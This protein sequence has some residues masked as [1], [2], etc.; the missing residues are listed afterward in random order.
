[1][2]ILI[3]KQIFTFNP[4]ARTENENISGIV[5]LL[6]EDNII[7]DS[8]LNDLN[9]YPLKI[10]MFWSAFSTANPPNGFETFDFKSFTGPD[11]DVARMLVQRMNVTRKL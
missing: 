5:H 3:D 8:N 7:V 9:G 11:A 2:H 1:M 6:D 10:E 4:F